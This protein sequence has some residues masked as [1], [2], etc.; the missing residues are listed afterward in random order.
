[1]RRSDRLLMT[2]PEVLRSQETIPAELA[3]EFFLERPFLE[4][5]DEAEEGGVCTEA[6]LLAMGEH[7]LVTLAALARGEVGAVLVEKRLPR[8]GE[9]N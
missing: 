9:F 1:M 2:D 7:I 3:V 5:L 4:L 8:P 6:D